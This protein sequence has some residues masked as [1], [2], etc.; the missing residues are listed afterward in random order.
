M[1][2]KRAVITGVGAVTPFGYG[3]EELW[4]GL[5]SGRSACRRMT[6]WDGFTGLKSLVGAPLDMRDARTIPRQSRRTM[7]PM[8]IFAAQAAELALDSAG[9][10]RADFAGN[11]QAGVIVGHTTGSPQTLTEV[12]R[13]LLPTG[14][15][16]L[17]TSSSFFRCLSHTAAL[18]LAQYL[19]VRGLVAATSAACASGLQAV[20]AAFDLIRL[21]R[22][23]MVLCGGAEE[24]HPTV[25][26]SFDILYA[27]SAGYNQNPEMTP[28]PFDR[29]RD[30]LVCAEGAGLLLLEEYDHAR[31][32]QAPI[33]GE[34]VGY[35]SC[36]NGS[37][38][39][40]SNPEAMVD[41]MRGALADAGLQAAD[42]DYLN[43]HATGTL[44]GDAAEAAAIREV[45]ADR[46]PTSSL[47]GHLGHTLG[48]SGPIELI[49]TLRMM[50]EGLLLP[51]R[52]LRQVADDCTD[53]QHL[54]KAL[55]K[56]T[57]HILKNSFA[58]GGIN[59]ALICARPER[60]H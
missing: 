52:N 40:Q 41:C 8:S 47:K 28:R 9:L 12:Y 2:L 16:G 22:Q 18:N 54:Q 56:P 45:F 4:Q 53:I 50:R 7:S 25:T 48:A 1:P 17:L 21:G 11:R 39:S 51:T 58:F 46:V 15:F 38:I 23:R 42:I 60:E 13:Q 44:Q 6:E 33:F 19:E 57:R 31:A 55:P 32:R 36:G 5:K 35:H 37:H 29:E 59:A 30:G 24:L 14:D 20:G 26:G 43:A 49:A 27:A 3:D 10:A 34:V